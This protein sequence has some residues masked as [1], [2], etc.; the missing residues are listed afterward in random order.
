MLVVFRAEVKP[1][2]T[3]RSKARICVKFMAEIRE[4]AQDRPFI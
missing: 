2:V 3:N 4:D 1:T